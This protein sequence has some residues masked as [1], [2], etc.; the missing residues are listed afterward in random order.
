MPLSDTAIRA[1]KPRDRAYKMGDAGGLFLLVTPAGGRLWRLKYRFAGKEQTLAFG[2]YPDVTLKDARERRDEARRLLA[3]GRN[4]GLEKKQAAIAAAISARTTFMAVAEEVIAKAEAE[5]KAP[6][7]L[8]KARWLLSR[9]EPDLGTRPVAE[10]EP[11]ELLVIAKK[12][13]RIGQHETAHRLLAFAGRVFR[14]AVVTARA[15][16]NPADA[17]R[18]ALSAPPIKHH[19]AI[20]EPAALGG[21]L[22]A[23]EGYDGQP[24]T[25]VALRLAPHVFLR[26]GELRQAE[27]RDIAFE[28]A[29]WRIPAGRAKM[30][31]EHVVPLS[32]QGV[33]LLREA[34]LLAGVSRYVFPSLRSLHRPM[35]ENTI[36]AALRRLGYSGDEMTG[37]GFRST[38]STLLNEAGRWTPDAIER[39]LAH[40]DG[41]QVRAAYHRGTHWHERVEMAQWWSNYL[42]TLRAGA[43]VIPLRFEAAS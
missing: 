14:Y 39:A 32:T 3:A 35:S 31:R 33:A 29:V 23:I 41:D 13:E 1:A 5:R 42:E 40:S 24:T 4:P 15:R 21:L 2:A 34:K 20:V 9:L 38:A 11:A 37:H 8:A 30:R 43:T 7:T 18:G 26:P 19:A 27:W 10:I 22:R 28:E 17:L 6:A 25:R 12:F 16:S 36:N